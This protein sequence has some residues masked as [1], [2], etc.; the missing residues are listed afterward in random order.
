MRTIISL[1]LTVAAILSASMPSVRAEAT[2]T[3]PVAG[4]A[5]TS[6]R[7]HVAGI[8]CGGNGCAPAQT[9]AVKHRKFQPL[10]HG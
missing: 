8:V 9:G 10:G 1:T 2:A 3:K 6:A 4:I 7:L 5:V